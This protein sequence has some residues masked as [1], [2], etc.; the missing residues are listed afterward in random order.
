MND[1]ELELANKFITE[2]C[3]TDTDFKRNV[4]KG[5]QDSRLDESDIYF[6]FFDNADQE[7][8]WDYA[9]TE[10][11]SD[12]TVYNFSDYII[13]EDLKPTIKKILDE[14]TNT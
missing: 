3:P 5:Y 4:L 7:K 1:Y 10:S 6:E 13:S 8:R 11:I 12:Y 9:H 14:Y 2:I